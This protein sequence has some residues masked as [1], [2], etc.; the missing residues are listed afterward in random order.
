VALA[1]T[2]KEAPE[3]AM[4]L[5][6]ETL[7]QVG[8]IMET[9]L[10]AMETMVTCGDRQRLVAVGTPAGAILAESGQKPQDRD[11]IVLGGVMRGTAAS[12]PRQ[13]VSKKT[14]AVLLVKNPDSVAM[15]A[16][17]VGCGQ[18]I[19]HCPARIDPAMITSYAEFGMYDKA[20]TAH[21][22]ACFECGLCGYYCIAR[23]PMLQYIR[24]AKCEL[25]KAKALAA[26]E[27]AQ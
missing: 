25:A 17:C 1:A 13:G 27:V 18:C 10:P 26:E 19:Q 21:I 22:D 12:S 16:P 6:L 4:V 24:L 9:G 20:E 11:R 3:D 5:G 7:F 2:G 15:D 14:S 8:R 23:R